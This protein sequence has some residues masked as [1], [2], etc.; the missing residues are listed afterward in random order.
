MTDSPKLQLTEQ[1]FARS[2]G[3]QLALYAVYALLGVAA[4]VYLLSLLAGGRV[5]LAET[6][7]V[8]RDLQV[9]VGNLNQKVYQMLS[10]SI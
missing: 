9:K 2:A 3:R 6:P 5:A 1:A 7:A 4:V 8:H 10:G